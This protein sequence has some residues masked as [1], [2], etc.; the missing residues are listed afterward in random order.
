[1]ALFVALKLAPM[2]HVLST[3]THFMLKKYKEEG[4][5]FEDEEKDTREVMTLC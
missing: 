3:V 2:E 5:T 1:M 4:I